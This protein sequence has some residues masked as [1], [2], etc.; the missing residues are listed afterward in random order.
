[1]SDRIST[2]Y[3]YLNY[4]GIAMRGGSVGKSSLHREW[5]YAPAF[6][7]LLGMPYCFSP[8]FRILSSSLVV[9]RGCGKQLWRKHLSSIAQIH[10]HDMA[11][12]NPLES[13]VLDR[14]SMRENVFLAKIVIEID[15]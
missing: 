1:M 11:K 9:E 12:F 7:S 3:M 13:S 10:H 5:H 8:S 6:R 15:A 4:R 14:G 2:R